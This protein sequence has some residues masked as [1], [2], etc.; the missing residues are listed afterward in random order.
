MPTLRTVVNDAAMSLTDI[1]NDAGLSHATVS[2]LYNGRPVSELTLRKVLFV[3]NQR[4][5][6]SYQVSDIQGVNLAGRD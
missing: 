2:K 3:L 4:L 5:G 6:T 1:A